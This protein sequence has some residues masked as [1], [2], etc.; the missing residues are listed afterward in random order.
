MTCSVLREYDQQQDSDR[1][2]QINK[3]IFS[4]SLIR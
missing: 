2:K 1:T 4:F 3:Y